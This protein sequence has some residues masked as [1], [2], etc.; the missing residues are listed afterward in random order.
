METINVDEL[1]IQGKQVY[2][3]E[4]LL[5]DLQ[6]VSAFDISTNTELA[7]A[8]KRRS[9]IAKVMPAIKKQRK[10]FLADVEAEFNEQHPE[11]PLIEQLA[12]SLLD[13]FD[14]EI[15]PYVNS[16][17]GER[18]ERIQPTIDEISANYEQETFK[19]PLEYANEEY[20][21]QTNNPAK[22]LERKIIDDVRLRG[23][24]FKKT[25]AKLDSEKRKAERL[26]DT[27]R[28]I[29]DGV[30]RNGVYDGEDIIKML[31]PLGEFLKN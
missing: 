2:G 4:Q 5:A 27:I 20:W 17:K 3:A 19:A 23:I 16:I 6:K 21:T 7:L 8:K 30:D 31:M 18:L 12:Q 11:F 28:Q 26:K 25:E 13:D 9:A 29:I 10:N 24:D 1:K 14:A 15:K 22:K